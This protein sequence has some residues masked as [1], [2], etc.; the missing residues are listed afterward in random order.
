MFNEQKAE[1]RAEIAQ[2]KEKVSGL[3][4][5]MSQLKQK[6]EERTQYQT[7]PSHR[8]SIPRDLSVRVIVTI[9]CHFHLI[10][11]AVKTFHDKASE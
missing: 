8:A 10:Q 1:L 4:S 2:V 11:E 7:A 3:V 9:L 6:L 5:E